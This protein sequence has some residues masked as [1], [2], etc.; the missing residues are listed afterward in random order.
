MSNNSGRHENSPTESIS[1]D[2]TNTLE[3][4]CLCKWLALPLLLSDCKTSC[5]MYVCCVYLLR[6]IILRPE[7]GFRLF[8]SQLMANR[9]KVKRINLVL[10]ESTIT[11]IDKVWPKKNFKSRSAFVDEASRRYVDRLHRANLIRQ[12]RNGY[13]ARAEESQVLVNEWEVVSGELLDDEPK[14]HQE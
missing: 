10:P 1:A 8:R 3:G 11:L 7:T 6:L 14:G 9:D 5:W 2:F 12:L 13:N 4:K